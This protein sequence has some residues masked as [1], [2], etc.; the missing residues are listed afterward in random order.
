M[1]LERVVKL[2]V[3]VG[4]TWLA[5]A[6][7]Y[8]AGVGAEEPAALRADLR[9]GIEYDDNPLRLQEED[10]R[11]GSAGSEGD[12]FDEAPDRLVRYFSSVDW[13][14]GLGQGGRVWADLRHGGKVFAR[15]TEADALLTQVRVGVRKEVGKSGWLGASADVKDRTERRSRLDYNRGGVGVSGGGALGAWKLQ[16]GLG[17]RYFAF[18]PSPA[19]SSTGPKGTVGARLEMSDEWSTWVDY[20]LTARFFERS[21]SEEARV[22]T[23]ARRDIYHLG[24]LGVGYRGAFIGEAT[25]SLMY[26]D[27]TIEAQGLLRHRVD[28]SATVALPWRLYATARLDVQR[29]ERGTSARPDALFFVDE[30]NRN[31]MVLSL[32]RD[33]GDAWE[34]EARYSRYREA[35]T[36]VDAAGELNYRRQ[37]VLVGLGYRVR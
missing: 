37:T 1:R 9:V 3:A 14:H 8:S 33:L 17:W 6:P 19:S 30:D 18:K 21:I 23:T 13:A 25:Y 29:A 22:N 11:G 15:R 36:G 26:N 16:A 5:S 34:V 27:S 28:L 20:G 32:A 4:S 7:A 31:V 35:F 12:D 2:C 10:P 24:A